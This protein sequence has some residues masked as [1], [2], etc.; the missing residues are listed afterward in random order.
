MKIDRGALARYCQLWARWRENEEFLKEHGQAYP[1]KDRRGE[2][3]GRVAVDPA[4][5]PG[6]EA[7][8]LRGCGGLCLRGRSL[9]FVEAELDPRP[10]IC[11]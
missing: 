7:R 9:V 8:C 2:V 4:G 5:K 10:E 1:V 11:R 6:K 3:I